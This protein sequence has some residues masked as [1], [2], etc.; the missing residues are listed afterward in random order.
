MINNGRVTRKGV[1]VGTDT[2]NVTVKPVPASYPTDQPWIPAE[3]VSIH[4]V[5]TPDITEY[6]VGDTIDHELL[7]YI[8]G[9]LG[10]ISPPLPLNLDDRTFRVYPTSPIID[11]DAQRLG[12]VGSRRQNAAVRPLRNGRHAFPA[13]T[14]SWWDTTQD[15]LR[16]STLAEQ[17]VNIIGSPIIT[18]TPG[19]D[20]AMSTPTAAKA[21]R[22]WLRCIATF[23]C[24]PLLL[25]AAANAA[26]RTHVEHSG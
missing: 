5:L 8:K 16:V 20:D 15:T 4:Q 14:I 26:P 3:E 1:R 22:P 10:S 7:V 23:L 6:K 2:V 21:G 24:L 9:N 13:V 19:T 18:E 17:K 11:D 12:V 25:H